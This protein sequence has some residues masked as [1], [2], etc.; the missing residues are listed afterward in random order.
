MYFSPSSIYGKSDIVEG[1]KWSE[2]NV[3][4]QL[5]KEVIYA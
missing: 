3:K 2:A 4:P 5:S 1:K